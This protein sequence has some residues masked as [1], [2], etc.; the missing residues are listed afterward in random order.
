MLWVLFEFCWQQQRARRRNDHLP[1]R[2]PR[3]P[4]QS[5]LWSVVSPP[6]SAGGDGPLRS[7]VVVRVCPSPERQVD[8]VDLG[9]RMSIER[10]D[11]RWQKVGGVHAESVILQVAVK[12]L[13]RGNLGDVMIIPAVARR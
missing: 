7:D 8:G 9:G 13:Q 4:V 3:A 5:V 6:S 11:R 10:H 2:S 12:R 1:Q